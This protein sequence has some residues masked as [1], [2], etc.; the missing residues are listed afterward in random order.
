MLIG[1]TQYLLLLICERQAI[2]AGTLEVTGGLCLETL[3]SFKINKKESH[4]H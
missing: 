4:E 2:A 3:V 1:Q